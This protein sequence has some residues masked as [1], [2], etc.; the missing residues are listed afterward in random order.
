MK[1]PQMIEIDGSYGEGGGQIVRTS[2]ALSALT[3]IPVRIKNIRRNRPKPGLA[4]QHVRA[5]EALAR[6]SR[7]ETRGVHLE[8]EEIEFIPGRISAG[9]YDVDIGTAGSV[10][11][12]IQCLLP[13][14]TAAEGPVTVTVRGGTD[15]RWSPTVDYLEYVALPAMRLFGVAAS[16]RCER[17]GYYPRGGGVV[18]LST[19][20]SKLRHARVER[21]DE[22]IRGISHCGSLPEHVARRQA[23]AAL[24]LLREN[25][26]EARIET[27]TVSS[28][29]PGSGITLWSGFR[30]SSALGERGVRA[31]DVG[32]EAANTIIE[33][34]RAGASVDVHLADQLIP[35]IALAGG[36][37]TA[38]EISSHTRTNIW[39]A[40]R[41]LG[42]RID[43]DEGEV[44]RI[45]STGSG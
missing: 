4:A 19:S 41:I 34:M 29:S 36:E 7:A 40:Q 33:E 27:Q 11:L 45:H 1:K 44:F 37:Y 20:P 3:G 12:L 18:V 9:S 39:T 26:Y 38:R 23:D 5:I 35:Y 8:S 2:V 15:V 32:R 10:T 21:I 17:R 28:S 43:I 6:I 16:F 13:A 42:C 25:G 24:E 31:E 14:L 22:S 30:G